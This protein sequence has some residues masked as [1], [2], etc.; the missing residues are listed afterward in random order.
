MSDLRLTLADLHR[1]L[2]VARQLAPE[3]RELLEK[4]LRDIEQAL[5]REAV[6][7]TG[8]DRAPGEALEGAAVRLEAEHPRVAGAVRALV[9]ALAKA[10]I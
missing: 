4:T 6:A 10:G 5:G 2:T 3:D 7:D 8:A 1:E 9:D